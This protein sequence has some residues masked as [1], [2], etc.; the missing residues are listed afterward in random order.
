M[1]TRSEAPVRLASGGVEILIGNSKDVLQKAI[2]PLHSKLYYI[3]SILG[4]A[5]L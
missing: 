4:F 5:R 1:A 3:A 2:K